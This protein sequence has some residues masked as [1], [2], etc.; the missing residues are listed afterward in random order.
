[1]SS[2]NVLDEK[3]HRKFLVPPQKIR[4]DVPVWLAIEIKGIDDACKFLTL[5]TSA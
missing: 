3:G 2:G 4:N 5:G 1:M